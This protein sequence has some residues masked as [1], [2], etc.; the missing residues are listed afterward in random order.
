MS[1]LSEEAALA[2]LKER[3]ENPPTKVKNDSLPA[4]SPMYFYCRICGHQSDVLPETYVG[5]PKKFCKECQILQN[6]GWL[7]E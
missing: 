3:K 4:G 2:A 7:E 5:S 1:Q 6:E